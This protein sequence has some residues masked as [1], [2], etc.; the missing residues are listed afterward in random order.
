MGR[1][2]LPNAVVPQTRDW[3]RTTFGPYG[4][5]VL[6]ALAEAFFTD[7]D[8]PSDR[9]LEKRFSWLVDDVDDFL[10]QASPALRYGSRIALML[11][12]LLP[13]FFIGR[14]ARSTSLPLEERER[15]LAKLEATSFPRVSV[16]VVMFKT[17]M[18]VLYFEHPEAAPHLGY[19]GRH[20]RFSRGAR[21]LPVHH[22]GAEP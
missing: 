12:D 14:F 10:S 15:Y 3:Q 11:V 17:L 21:Q 1:R 13:L 7:P 19:D 18:T 9:G 4:K 2:T 6:R 5:R 22:A 16:L 20:E 8:D